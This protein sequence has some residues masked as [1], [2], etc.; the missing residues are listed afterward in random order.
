[1]SGSYDGTARVW[2]IES[3]EQTVE[4]QLLDGD[5]KVYSSPDSSKLFGTLKNVVSRMIA[6]PDGRILFCGGGGFVRVLDTN[7]G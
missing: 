7:T 3:G 4:C 2:D 1:M 6:I 5:E